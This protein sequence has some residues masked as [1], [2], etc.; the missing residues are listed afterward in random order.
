MTHPKSE[1]AAAVTLLTDAAFARHQVALRQYLV[2]R[3]RDP[4]E[5]GD[6]AQEVFA[7]Y[8]RRKDQAESIR[9]PVAFLFG[10]AANVVRERIEAQQSALVEFD[11]ELAELALDA[12]EISRPDPLAE[13]LG[14]QRDLTRALSQLP[15][16]HR[17]MVM[18]VKGEGL[19]IAEAARLTGFTEGTVMVYLCEARAKLKKLLKDYA[20]T[21]ERSK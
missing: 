1:R 7:R 4:A 17:A 10:I 14:L 13:A 21:E 8:L 5:G 15:A 2:R 16:N 20:G 19:S 3:L 9:N 12:G 11:S 18:L 6:L